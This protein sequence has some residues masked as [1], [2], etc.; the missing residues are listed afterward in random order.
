MHTPAG[1]PPLIATLDWYGFRLEVNLSAG[2]SIAITLDPH[3]PH[4]SFFAGSPAQASPLRVGDYVADVSLGGSCNAEVVQYVPHCHGTHTECKAHL[5]KAAGNVLDVIE[6]Q[7]CLARTITLLGTPAE[8][9]VDS[10]P[11][12]LRADEIVLTLQELRAHLDDPGAPPVEALIIRTLPNDTEKL[13]RDYALHPSYPVLSSE[14]TG[15]LAGQELKHLLI[16]TPS[17]DRADDNGLLANHRRWWGM[18]GHDDTLQLD[19]GARSV[20]EMIYVPEIVPDGLYWLHLE[21]QPLRSDATSS[22]PVIYPVK[23]KPG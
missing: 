19:P 6:Q 5:E 3:G 12:T 8:T 16:D 9:G 18:D 7:P 13:T 20:T 21:L 22:R 17:L 2:R 10:Y 11:V 23:I 14:A 1:Q 4:A 15:W